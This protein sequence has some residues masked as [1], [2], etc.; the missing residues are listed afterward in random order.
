MG[1]DLRHVRRIIHIGPPSTLE[2]K[3]R[4]ELRQGKVGGKKLLGTFTKIIPSTLKSIV[5]NSHL[6]L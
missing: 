6:M 3:W 1:A 5:F 4:G 2:S